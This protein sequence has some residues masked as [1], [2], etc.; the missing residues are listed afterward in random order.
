MIHE[1]KAGSESKSMDATPTIEFDFKTK[2][3]ETKA[4]A[5]VSWKSKCFDLL[6]K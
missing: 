4:A 2:F 3:A 6:F 1:L 5:K